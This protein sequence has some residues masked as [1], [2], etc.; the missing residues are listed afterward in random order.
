MSNFKN[1]PLSN[2]KRIGKFETIPFKEIKFEHYEPAFNHAL[3]EAKKDIKEIREDKNEPT[4]ENTI[5]ALENSGELLNY[6]SKVY[7]NLLGAESDDKMKD[8]AQKISPLISAFS[9]SIMTD[10]IIFKRVKTIHDSRK[11][12]DLDQEQ[13]RL[14]EK[15]Y[16][17]FVRNGALLDDKEKEELKKIDGQMAKLSPQFTKNLLGAT[18]AFQLVITDE[19]ELEGLPQSAKDAAKYAAKQM[20]EEGWLFNLQAPSVRP[21]FK[22]A[23][24]RDLREKMYRA[25]TSRAFNDKF[26]N[27]KILKEVANLRYKRAKLLGFKTH[28][29]YTLTERMAE[30]SKNVHEFLKRIFTVAMP[31]AKEELNEIQS[32][33][34]ELDGIDDLQAWDFSFYSE[35]LRQKKFKFDEEELRPYFKAENVIDGIFEVANKMYG[36]NF[37]PITDIQV[38]NEDVRTYEVIDEKNDHVG[39]LYIDLYPRETKRSGAWMTTFQTQGMLHDKMKRP[40]VA[41]VA[42]LT[43]ATD[44]SPALLQFSEVRTI[45]HEFGHALHALLSNCH[46]RTLASPNVYWDFVELPS[47]IM[48]NWL[49]E[50]KA[51]KI[52]AKH[53]QTGEDLPLELIKKV[54]KAENFNKGSANIRQLKFGMLDM[55]WHDTD[56]RDIDD[57]VE[58]EENTL[59]KLNLLP[60]VD[61]SLLSTAFAHIFA[62]GYS[63]GYYSYK[64]A[65]VLEADAFEKF[66]E[67]GIFNQKTARSFKENILSKGNSEHPMKLYVNF[68]GQEPDPDALLRRDGLLK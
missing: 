19:T 49:M 57:V 43:P 25:F 23:K 60:Q 22:Y 56:P 26:D 46:Y 65:E 8:L 54:K 39:L 12:L 6:V 1:N 51:L 52:F 14:L 58:F 42:N 33:A 59:D 66:K 37:K 61:T 30:N 9:N 17:D 16:K 29:E 47:Q 64:W 24:N 27:R 45:F 53:Y 62:G 18:N 50:E 2:G 7:F 68:K 32:L 21:I 63:A 13:I 55:A 5:E 48:E 35:K 31:K 11:K 38:Y 41:V 20:K 3:E 15:N 4:F 28:A 36:L 67:E 44:K 40:H 34:K 10:S